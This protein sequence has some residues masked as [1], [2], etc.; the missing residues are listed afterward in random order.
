[1]KKKVLLGMSGGVDSSVAAIL[2]QQQGYEVIGA[3]MKL[4]D[5]ND[6]ISYDAKKVCDKLGIKHYVLDLKEEFKTCVIKNFIHTYDI[7]KTPNPCI[8]CNKHLKFGIFYQKAC[9][10]RCDYIATGH[11]AK[12][13][14]DK[15]YNSMVL[16]KSDSQ[17][18]DQ[19]YVLYNIPQE[20]IPKIIFPL[21]DFNDKLEIRKIAEECGLDIA[22]KPDSQEICFIPDNDYAKFLLQY[23]KTKPGNIVH[24]NGSILGKHQGLIHYTIGQRKGLGISYPTPLYVINLNKNTNEVIVGDEKDIYSSTLY[25]DELNY[26]L[27]IDLTKPIKIKA[28][29]RYSSKEQD[30]ILYNNAEENNAKIEFLQPQRAITPGQSVVFYIDDVVLRW[31]KNHLKIQ[32]KEIEL[33]EK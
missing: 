16:K 13:E 2:L 4:L 32:K 21:S 3:T 22:H 6:K 27:N 19:S 5:Q 24:K 18:K 29:I 1:M 12:V 31:R 8:E 20:I 33:Y 9:E 25:A 10:L 11:Y 28:K 30:A 26:T 14:F 15:K 7:A 17:N 23:I